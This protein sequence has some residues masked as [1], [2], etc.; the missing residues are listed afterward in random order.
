MDM[1]MHIALLRPCLKGISQRITDVCISCEIWKCCFTYESGTCKRKGECK[2]DEGKLMKKEIK[3]I[4]VFGHW[5]LPSY[6][7]RMAEQ[8]WLELF[9]TTFWA[10][11]FVFSIF[12]P[13]GS[14][15]NSCRNNQI[16]TLHCKFLTMD[17]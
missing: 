8:V 12:G 11:I 3:Y 4:L 15:L 5:T 13:Y 1:P 16:K 9:A 2:K 6:C 14:M 7:F 10:I 17:L